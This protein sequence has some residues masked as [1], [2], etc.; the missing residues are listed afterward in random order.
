MHTHTLVLHWERHTYVH[1]TRVSMGQPGP[2]GG[3]GGYGAPWVWSDSSQGDGVAKPPVCSPGYPSPSPGP[4]PNPNPNPSVNPNPNPNPDQVC[5]PRGPRDCATVSELHAALARLPAL[6]LPA[7]DLP[8]LGLSWV[9][10]WQPSRPSSRAGLERADSNPNPNP[11]PNPYPNPNP[12]PSPN[13][14][15]HGH[16]HVYVH[17]RGQGAL[18]LTL[19]LTLPLTRCA[20]ICARTRASSP[21]PHPASRRAG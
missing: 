3:D 11:N 7:V 6:D 13:P 14:N 12:N 15:A 17:V 10:A 4:N 9:A 8:D 19:T 18:T 20:S 21:W 16:G 1:V 2:H 5:S